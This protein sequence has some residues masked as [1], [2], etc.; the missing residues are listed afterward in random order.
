MITFQWG[1]IVT[2]FQNPKYQ[3]M[4]HGCNCQCTMGAGVAKAIAD[5]YPQVAE[6]DK[7]TKKG[8]LSK[9]G[10]IGLVE[11]PE[12]YV[13]N[14]YTQGLYG[15]GQ[16]QLDLSAV[17]NGFANLYQHLKDNNKLRSHILIPRIGSGLA[18][19]DWYKILRVIASQMGDVSIT[20]ALQ[21]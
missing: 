6:A 21:K 11:V 18:G 3:F 1:D 13:V 16:V 7:A 17:E 12:G 4:V 14:M 15:V 20:V 5:R 8:D 10:T 19:G 2:M 9:L